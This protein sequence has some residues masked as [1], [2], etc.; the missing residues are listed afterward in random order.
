MTDYPEETELQKIREWPYQD[1]DGLMDYISKLWHWPEY[2][3]K[4]GAEWH[5]STGGWSG[6]EEILDAMIDNTVFWALYW[7]STRRGG[8]VVLSREGVA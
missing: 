3:W 2:I 6:N 5:L 7:Q 8:H 1:F 4:E